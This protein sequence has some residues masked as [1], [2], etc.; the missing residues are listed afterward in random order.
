MRISNQA[1]V[2]IAPVELPC[3]W[4]SVSRPITWTSQVIDSVSMSLTNADPLAVA[5]AAST[6]SQTLKTV[7]TK[8][9][10]RALTAIHTALLNAKHEILAANAK[11]VVAAEKAAQ[12]GELSQSVL[13]RLDLGKKGKWE[14]MLKGVLDVR[15]L[16]DPGR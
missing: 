3:C 5:Q 15:D 11:D 7:S 8:E 6:S 16:E 10:N 2:D 13:K 4:F 9:R 1:V 12:N 14:E